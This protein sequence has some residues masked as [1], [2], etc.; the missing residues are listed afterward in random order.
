MV[1]GTFDVFLE[2]PGLFPETVSATISAN[3]ACDL[4]TIS[5]TDKAIKEISSESEIFT[6]NNDG[7]H[8]FCILQ[9]EAD[10]SCEVKVSVKDKAGKIVATPVK[11]QGLIKG[12]NIVLW[13]PQSAVSLK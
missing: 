5:M 12:K 13:L 9:L 1:P 10:R 4:G 6:P 11:K 2:R 3:Q 7:D 8:D